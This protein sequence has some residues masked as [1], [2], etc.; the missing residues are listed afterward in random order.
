MV[1]KV[2]IPIIV[3]C[4]L[5]KIWW[6]TLENNNSGWEFRDLQKNQKKTQIKLESL[7]SLCLRNGI[8]SLNTNYC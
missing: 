3:Y 1:S 6:T 8:K 4:S 2:W 5:V 7:L